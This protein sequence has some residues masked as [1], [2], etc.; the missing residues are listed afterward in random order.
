MELSHITSKEAA[1]AALLQTWKGGIN[2]GKMSEEKSRAWDG[3]LTGIQ[4][5]AI[6]LGATRYEIMHTQFEANSEDHRQHLL[7]AI[8]DDIEISLKPEML[9]YLNDLSKIKEEFGL[10][11][12]FTGD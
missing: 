10:L 9:S 6:E 7:N 2:E 1:L 4:D 3:M 11:D 8:V 5:R 12:P